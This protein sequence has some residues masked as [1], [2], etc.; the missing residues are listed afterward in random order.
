MPYTHLVVSTAVTMNKSRK[1]QCNSSQASI[2]AVVSAWCSEAAGLAGIT[3]NHGGD[4][5]FIA[6]GG[7][8]R[9]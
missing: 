1:S 6:G 9:I 5:V 2:S 3:V 4:W 8:A 7:T